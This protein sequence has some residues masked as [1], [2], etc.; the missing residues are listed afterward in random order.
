MKFAAS[1]FFAVIMAVLSTTVSAGTLVQ[2]RTLLGDIELELYD[3]D[4]PA[5]V[6]NFLD[7]IR[8][9]RYDDGFI[10]RWSPKFVIQGGAYYSTNRTQTSGTVFDVE[11][12]APILNEYSVGRKFSNTYGTIA[13]ARVG[14]I[15]NSATSQWFI[16]LGD[17]SFLD[18]VDG[19]FTVFGRLLRGANVLDV[20][21]SKSGEKGIDQKHFGGAFGEL[22]VFTANQR[23]VFVD[24][25]LL[26]VRVRKIRGVSEISWN[27]VA[28]KPNV[29]EF[30][31]TVPP[32]WQTLSEQ[33]GTGDSMQVLDNSKDTTRF[34]RVR[35]AY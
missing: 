1:A 26:N 29:V 15:T 18:S 28:G 9:G 35:V 17:N 4:K 10:H 30:T 8:T 20:F 31:Q 12:F 6:K 21:V 3:Q 25:S 27:S 2:F 5:T 13:M 16:N 7:Y 19:G 24:I 14:G 34:Y 11:T 33:A 32:V 23:L 22:P